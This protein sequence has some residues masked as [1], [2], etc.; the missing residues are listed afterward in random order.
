MLVWCHDVLRESMLEGHHT[1]VI[2]LGP[3]RLLLD[4]TCRGGMFWCVKLQLTL[5]SSGCLWIY[6]LNFFH[7]SLLQ[8]LACVLGVCFT[9]VE[10]V[11]FSGASYCVSYH[12]M[13][14]FVTEFFLYRMYVSSLIFQWRQLA[15]TYGARI[16]YD[17]TWS[18]L[19][20]F[21]MEK[22]VLV[23]SSGP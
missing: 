5:V 3:R 18:L 14:L 1:K 20:P 12:M 16:V 4:G 10:V 7:S 15:M 8:A 23:P 17:S 6:R 19:T 13:D 11:T 22:H 9:D 21:V 2:K